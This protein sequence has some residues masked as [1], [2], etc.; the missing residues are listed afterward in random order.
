MQLSP[1][2]RQ[3]RCS[4]MCTY[5][6][7]HLLSLIN[8]V[9][10]CKLHSPPCVVFWMSS[11]TRAIWCSAWTY[12]HCNPLSSVTSIQG[13]WLTSLLADGTVLIYVSSTPSKW[14]SPDDLLR[15]VRALKAILSLF[16]VTS[17]SANLS[18][19]SIWKAVGSVIRG[20]VA[21]RSASH[22]KSSLHNASRSNCKNR[23]HALGRARR[24]IWQM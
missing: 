5:F 3:P 11:E 17:S 20:N 8:Y 14:G 18:S 2:W 4:C 7:A 13:T 1:F 15:T 22:V 16:N 24:L 9:H 12:E 23:R 21:V 19:R 6:I 10:R